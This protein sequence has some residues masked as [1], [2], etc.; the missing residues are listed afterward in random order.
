MAEE[1]K[2]S[3]SYACEQGFNVWP[4]EVPLFGS[5]VRS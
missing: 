5:H 2:A 3:W 4:E 1:E